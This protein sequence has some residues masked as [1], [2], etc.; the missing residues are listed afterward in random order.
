M[1]QTKRNDAS[2]REFLKN[3]GQAGVL[4]AGAVLLKDSVLS[5]SAQAQAVNAKPNILMIVVD[6]ERDWAWLPSNFSF[7]T[8]FPARQ[9][10]RDVGVRFTNYHVHTSPCSPSRSV[11]YT[12]QH[13]DTTGIFDNVIT[14]WQDD[15]KATIKTIGVMLKEQGYTTAYRGKWH[16]QA[17]PL[18]LIR[19]GFDDWI[20]GDFDDIKGMEGFEMDTDIAATSADFIR[21]QEGATQPWFLSV[22]LINPHDIAAFPTY[23]DAL[24]QP[25]SIEAL[26]GYQTL[27]TADNVPSNYS[28]PLSSKPGAHKYWRNFYNNFKGKVDETDR[29]VWATMLNHYVHF[30]KD[31]DAHVLTVLN[32]LAESAQ[33]E[34]TVIIFTSDHGELAGAHGLR[35]KGPTTY[36]EQYKVPLIVVDPRLPHDGVTYKHRGVETRAFAGSVDLVPMILRLAD[37]AINVTNYSLLGAD[38]YNKVLVQNDPSKLTEKAARDS[39]LFTYDARQGAPISGSGSFLQYGLGFIRGILGYDYRGNLVKYARYSEPNQVNTSLNKMQWELFDYPA[40]GDA[41]VNNRL[42]SYYPPAPYRKVR[43]NMNEQLNALITK[44]MRNSN[45]SGPLSKPP[46][47]PKVGCQ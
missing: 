16:L 42:T 19:Y 32:A 39:I 2:R 45:A 4:T 7:G 12:G 23:Y 47:Y 22:N 10:L 17:A 36:K 33:L 41:E 25:A 38:L 29:N 3:V 15:M 21:S 40:D 27:L 31:A 46:T 18:D 9:W 11:M 24:C 34:N 30:M 44:E 28:D 37:P 6:E 8:H 26:P 13:T 14:G 5:G 1:Q 35:A 20:R 43:D